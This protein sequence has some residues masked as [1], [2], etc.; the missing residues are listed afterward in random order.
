MKT[1]ETSSRQA[2][3]HPGEPISRWTLA[4]DRNSAPP[5]AARSFVRL[6]AFPWRIALVLVGFLVQVVLTLLMWELVD[7]TLSLMEVWAE[8]ARKHLEL[9]L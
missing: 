4:R 3:N 5:R 8:L 2:E 9:T 6:G 1:G 7:L